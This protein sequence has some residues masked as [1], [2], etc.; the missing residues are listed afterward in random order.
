[1]Y[2]DIL[3]IVMQSQIFETI[4]T[5][6]CSKRLQIFKLYSSMPNDFG[7]LGRLDRNV[8]N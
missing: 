2:S 3:C 8:C 4:Q 5:L 6:P 7:E 1:M